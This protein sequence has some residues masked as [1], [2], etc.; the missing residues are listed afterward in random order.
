[1]T[2]EERDNYLRNSDTYD[3]NTEHPYAYKVW[4]RMHFGF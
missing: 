2:D 3:V 4:L 1:M